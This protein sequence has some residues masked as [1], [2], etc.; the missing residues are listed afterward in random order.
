MERDP[1]TGKAD[2]CR[3]LREARVGVSKGRSVAIDWARD[4]GLV[5]QCRFATSG[6]RRGWAGEIALQPTSAKAIKSLTLAGE[7]MNQIHNPMQILPA[8][9]RTVEGVASFLKRNGSE[10]PRNE[11]MLRSDVKHRFVI[12]MASLAA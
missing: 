5:A 6:P 1:S 10:L 4:A 8:N 2:D 9:R 12:E 11:R 3:R 7:F